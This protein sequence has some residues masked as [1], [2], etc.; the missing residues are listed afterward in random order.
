[1]NMN[2][3]NVSTRFTLR[4]DSAGGTAL[5]LPRRNTGGP[6]II[7]AGMFAIFAAVWVQQ[8]ARLNLHALASIFDLMSMLF[9]LF[10]IIGWSVAVMALGALTVFLLFFGES[11]RLAG[12]RLIYVLNVGPFRMITEY[13]LALMR[14]LRVEAEPGGESARVRFEY[15]DIRRG[16]GDTMPLGSAE[17]NLEI[18]N[19]AMAALALAPA[20]EF[21]RPP[22]FTPAKFDPP[23]E[24]TQRPLPLFSMLVLVAANL[25]PLLSVL[26]GGWKLEEV[27][28]LF[29]AESAV[30]GF[31]TLLKIAVVVRWWAPFPGLFFAG[32]FGGFMAIHFLFIYELFV[33]GINAR[34]PDPG[35]LEALG[36]LFAPLWPALLAL[37]LSHGVSFALN[38]IA[39]REYER[40]TV[41]SLMKAPYGRIVVMQ[42]TLIFGGWVVMLLK[43]PM[44][45]LVLLIVFKVA[46]DL[47]AHYGERASSTGN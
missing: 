40:T 28:V 31:Y 22:E 10:W 5:E 35:A 45:A 36:H 33:R 7:V 27:M 8:I 24:L 2:F 21:E 4:D 37:L 15:D 41:A 23:A 42:F 12:G 38:F 9:D 18:L 29:W 26:V 11:A 17:R 25:I 14:N 32:H 6:T 44:P 13:K 20:A 43:N 3:R 16:L 46:A 47:R 39:H 34:S 19:G 1:M 30:I